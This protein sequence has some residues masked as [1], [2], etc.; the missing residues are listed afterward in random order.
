MRHALRGRAEIRLPPQ[1]DYARHAHVGAAPRDALPAACPRGR[2]SKCTPR[3]RLGCPLSCS[4]GR[5]GR[6]GVRPCAQGPSSRY[7]RSPCRW[8]RPA[9]SSSS[10]TV[11]CS[12][13]RLRWPIADRPHSRSVYLCTPTSFFL[14]TVSTTPSERPADA[15]PTGVRAPHASVAPLAASA[16]PSLGAYLAVSGAVVLL[17]LCTCLYVLFRPLFAWVDDSEDE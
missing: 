15:S 5:F 3:D 9:A 12:Q 11:R 7:R 13:R 16:R 14:L 10:S 6:G 17:P 4:H 8:A 1:F 2:G